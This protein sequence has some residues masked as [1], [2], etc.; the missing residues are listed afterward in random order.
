MKRKKNYTR[1]K[2]DLKALHLNA[3]LKASLTQT[4]QRQTNLYT[5]FTTWTKIVSF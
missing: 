3:D 2:E 5:S 4:R 1:E